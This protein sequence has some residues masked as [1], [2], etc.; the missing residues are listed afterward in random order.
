MFPFGQLQYLAR[1]R[2]GDARDLLRICLAHHGECRKT[3]R[4]VFRTV[5]FAMM[6]RNRH[7]GGIGFQHQGFQR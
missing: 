2:G 5:S 1:I 6:L 7:I 4:Q 3:V